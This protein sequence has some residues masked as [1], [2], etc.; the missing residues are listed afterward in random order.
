MERMAAAAEFLHA[1][2]GWGMCV[3][4]LAGII[5]LYK[6][7]NKIIERHNEKFIDALR[8][9]TAMLQQNADESRRVEDLLNRIERKMETQ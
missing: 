6:S 7:M 2:G 8:E 5:Y 4:L 3:I 1:F 9:T